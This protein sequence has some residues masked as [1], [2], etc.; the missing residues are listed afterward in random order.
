MKNLFLHFSPQQMFVFR[1][2]AII[3]FLVYAV[4]T[5][6]PDPVFFIFLALATFDFIQHFYQSKETS[7]MHQK[8]NTLSQQIANGEL[9][10]RITEIPENSPLAKI[11]YNFNSAT[12]QLETFMREVGTVFKY[13]ENDL[14]YRKTFPVGLH[15]MFANAL[16]NIDKSIQVM[17]TN[18]W[19]NHKSHMTDMLDTLKTKNLLHNLQGAQKDLNGIAEQINNVESS[20]KVAA[21]N[22]LDSKS[23]VNSVIQNTHAIVQKINELRESSLAL[24]KSSSE[25]AEIINLIAS[26]A[27]QTNLLA[28]NAAIEAARAGEHGRGFAV[29]ADEVRTLAAN[30]KHATDKIENIISKLLG[31]SEIISKKSQEM[32]VLSNES[33]KLISTFEQDFSDFSEIA[34]HTYEV[35]SHA[36]MICYV[37][38]AK[39]DHMVYMQRAYRAID[40]GSNS[41]EAQAVKVDELH[42]R[43]G[44]WLVAE[45]GGL[46]Y[47]HLPSYKAI[48]SPHAQVHGNVHSSIN[49][50]D[51]EWEHSLQLQNQIIEHMQ[52]AENGSY[53]LITHLDNMV[54]EKKNSQPSSIR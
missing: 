44:K 7:L 30:T 45:N 38:L 23:S 39:L 32:E 21:N 31:S 46:K 48:S 12:N 3:L 43:F 42:C 19:E 40:L 29:V 14:F 37:S 54:N 50:L 6:G 36:S 1:M 4:Y 41:D 52:Q 5:F 24:D 35:S 22:A 34:Q 18:F 49:L 17:E 26:I 13:A 51:T 11:A 20:S 15:G 33:S 25:I 53:N 9:E 2:V 8:L 10:Y 28:L 27:D 47:S 16:K